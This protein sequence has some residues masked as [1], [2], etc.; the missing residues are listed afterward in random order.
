MNITV[1]HIRDFAKKYGFAAAVMGVLALMAVVIVGKDLLGGKGGGG[2]QGMMAGGPGGGQGRP[3]GGPGAGRGGGGMDAP[4]VGVSVVQ[5][6]TFSD[7]VQALGTAQARESITIQS[8]VQDVIRAI[9]F[10]SGQRVAKGQV[11]VEMSNVEQVA[12]LNEARAQL[13]VDQRAYERY[14]QL[15]DKGYVT[16]AQYDQAEAAYARS[17]A[18]VAGLQSRI[19]DRQIRAPFAGVV[20]LR[21]ASPGQLAS[22]NDSLGTL[23][24]VSVIKLDFDVP[25]TQIAKMRKGAPLEARTAAFPGAKFDGRIDE[26]DSRINTTSRTVRVRALIPNRDGRIK[27]GML[28][29]VSVLSNQKPQLAIPELALTELGADAYVYRVVQQGPMAKVEQAYVKPGRRANG[30][31]EVL[32]G[33]AAGDMVIVEG[34]NRVRPGQP[35]R[36]KP[37]T[38]SGEP[39]DVPAA[40]TGKADARVRAAPTKAEATALGA[41]G[42]FPR[43]RN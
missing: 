1:G 3:G 22:P 31:I 36:V 32:E 16:R 13:V 14:K 35:V 30:Y 12:D 37:L 33:I 6:R 38:A 9:R 18:N 10:E 42:A 25:E 4:L 40:E 5:E 17:R 23:D 21:T 2:G 11:L 41:S 7:S 29:T 26:I 28:M 8:K 15:V 27:P 20:G 19:A 24:D 34:V 43:G 39:A